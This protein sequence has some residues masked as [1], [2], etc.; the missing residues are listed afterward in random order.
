M[1]AKLSLFLETWV[2]VFLHFRI[3][4]ILCI[5]HGILKVSM[6]SFQ[7]LVSNRAF[8][9]IESK[10]RLLLMRPIEPAATGLE[11]VCLTVV[12]EWH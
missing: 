5:C 8:S 2:L 7:G 9:A 6:S 12:S 10:G 3:A 11:G 1:M 4:S